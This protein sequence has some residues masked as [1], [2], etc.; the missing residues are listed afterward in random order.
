MINYEYVTCDEV[1]MWLL[2]N[3]IVFSVCLQSCHVHYCKIKLFL[4]LLQPDDTLSWTRCS[5]YITNSI[6]ALKNIMNAI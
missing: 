5:P 6:Y 4:M 3:R 2:T 1:F